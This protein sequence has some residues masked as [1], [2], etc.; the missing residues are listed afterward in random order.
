[1]ESPHK[2]WKHNVCVCVCVCVWVMKE[3]HIGLEQ[4]DG[5]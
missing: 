5:K 3:V 2:T 1:M 4:L